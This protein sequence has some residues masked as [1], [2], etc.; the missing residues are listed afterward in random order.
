MIK[1]V[2]NAYSA[3][4]QQE[5]LSDVADFQFI[6]KEGS[7]YTSKALMLS[8]FSSLSSMLCVS[9]VSDHSLVAVTLE[10]ITVSNIEFAMKNLLKFGNKTNLGQ[11]LGVAEYPGSVQSMIITPTTLPMKVENEENVAVESEEEELNL[12]DT[13]FSMAEEETVVQFH[14]QSMTVE[15]IIHE[16]MST[17]EIKPA[18]NFECTSCGKVFTGSWNLNRHKRLG[19]EKARIC[20]VCNKSITGFQVFLQHSRTCFY[21]CD[22]CDYKHKRLDRYQ[23]HKRK[24]EREEQESSYTERIT[25]VYS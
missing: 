20:G 18:P 6:T 13:N 2:N 7:Y 19:H 25:V 21:E 14:G 22:Q 3:I 11:I 4:Y 17:S 9:C 8:S 16:S 12:F 23:G 5:L 15:N 10:D 1:L 24:H